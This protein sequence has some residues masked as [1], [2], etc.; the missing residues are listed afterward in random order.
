VEVPTGTRLADRQARIEIAGPAGLADADPHLQVGRVE[1]VERAR[2]TTAL[3]QDKFVVHPKAGGIVDRRRVACGFG[4]ADDVF[5][6]VEAEPVSRA[7]STQGFANPGVGDISDPDRERFTSPVPLIADR[8]WF[9]PRA[10][11]HAPRQPKPAQC[12]PI[13]DYLDIHREGIS[14]ARFAVTVP[15]L[16]G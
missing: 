8:D 3:H 14:D 10:P 7:L 13:G 2:S 6:L 1:E 9:G 16:E 4:R 15:M 11:V 12:R 5:D